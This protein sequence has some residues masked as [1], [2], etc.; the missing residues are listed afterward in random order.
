MSPTSRRAEQA[1]IAHRLRVEGGGE[2]LGIAA[3]AREMG[4]SV[5]Y[6]GSLLT[7]PTGEKDRARKRKYLKRCKTC[8][9]LCWGDYCVKHAAKATG[10]KR[11]KWTKLMVIEAIQEWEVEHGRLPTSPEWSRRERLPEWVP[12]VSAVY[13]L[14]GKGGWNKAIEAAGFTP[15]PAH[16]PEYAQASPGDKPFPMSPEA[17]ERIAEEHKALYAEDPDNPMFRGLREGW[18]IRREQ[19][20]RD[21]QRF[22][23]KQDAK[24]KSD[25][26]ADSDTIHPHGS[27]SGTEGPE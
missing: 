5:S 7:D 2:G 13:R 6:A 14:F 22:L 4:I 16:A 20:E 15:R 21:N 9:V 23:A 3:I 18:D 10:K 24:E 19:R 17:R 27:R 8:H 11:R 1:A 12:T 25:I 26:R